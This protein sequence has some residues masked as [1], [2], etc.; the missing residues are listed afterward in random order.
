MEAGGREGAEAVNDRPSTGGGADV[1]VSKRPAHHGER[2]DTFGAICRGK[3]A[4][5]LD[6]V[7]LDDLER[8]SIQMNRAV[9]RHHLVTLTIISDGGFRSVD[10]QN[11][12]YQPSKRPMR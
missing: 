7:A 8:P 6:D 10:S 4:M 5:S 1:D 12:V 11:T 2:R 3:L 9:V